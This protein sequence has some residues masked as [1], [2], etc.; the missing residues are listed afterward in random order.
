MDGISIQLSPTWVLIGAM[1]TL[2]SLLRTSM[3]LNGLMTSISCAFCSHKGL[4]FTAETEFYV[5]VSHV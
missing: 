1:M 4:I 3:P 2:G 5:S